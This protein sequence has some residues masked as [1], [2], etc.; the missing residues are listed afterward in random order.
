MPGQN[1]P[2]TWDQPR[3]GQDGIAPV[4]VNGVE[5]GQGFTSFSASPAEAQGVAVETSTGQQVPHVQMESS[6]APLSIGRYE[7][8]LEWQMDVEDGLRLQQN[9]I[10]LSRAH[11]LNL[12]LD[13][14]HWELWQG[15]GAQTTFVLSRSTA[16]GTTGLPFV[17]RPARCLVGVVEQVMVTGAPA[18]GECQ[19]SQTTDSTS[20]ALGAA[21]ADG[22]LVNLGYY[23]LLLPYEA[24]G[25]EEIAE[26]NNGTFSVS[27]TERVPRRKYV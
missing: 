16:Y 3:M 1:G 14:V 8:D 17:D 10:S 6:A 25:A 13:R 19:L 15:D 11:K 20:M 18:P 7:F 27:F 12:Y 24:E 9:I 22:A 2:A 26:F 21:P 5:Y 23:P 4:F